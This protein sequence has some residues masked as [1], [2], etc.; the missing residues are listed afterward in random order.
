MLYLWTVRGVVCVWTIMGVVRVD[1]KGC[2]AC[3][4]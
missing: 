3:G 4:Q 1:N 2:C